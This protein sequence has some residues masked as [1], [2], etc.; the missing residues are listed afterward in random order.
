M[1]EST[2]LSIDIDLSSNVFYI[3]E[4]IKLCSS[5]DDL[6]SEN[7]KSKLNL[8]IRVCL[9]CAKS[10]EEANRTNA[11]IFKYLIC[12]YLELDMCLTGQKL[13]F[14]AI[15]SLAIENRL[16]NTTAIF[17]PILKQ[18]PEKAKDFF[19]KTHKYLESMLEKRID[20][21]K[22]LL[23]LIDFY[24]ENSVFQDLLNQSIS[25]FW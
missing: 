12:S 2:Q 25:S 3:L 14:D 21:D 9:D 11:E 7:R 10:I 15:M 18:Q 16:V 19:E 22:T 6:L 1:T 17:E 23:F 24:L 5:S 4:T 8:A 20:K 13:S